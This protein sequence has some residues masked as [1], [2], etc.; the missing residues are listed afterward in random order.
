MIYFQA[1]RVVL[2]IKLYLLPLVICQDTGAD[3]REQ[4][5]DTIFLRI[6][7]ID[8]GHLI[9]V[10]GVICLPGVWCPD[11][12]LW[13]MQRGN[14]AKSTKP[15]PTEGSTHRGGDRRW[16]SDE[17]GKSRVA[18]KGGLDLTAKLCPDDFTC[19]S[20]QGS[21]A[22]TSGQERMCGRQQSVYNAAL[23]GAELQAAS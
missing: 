3:R 17:R 8:G 5:T 6:L 13:W 12:M 15:T 21:C 10:R 7:Q 23:P 11:K 19:I 14:H 18:S 4:V 2:N 9:T 20:R 1:C 16:G 22:F